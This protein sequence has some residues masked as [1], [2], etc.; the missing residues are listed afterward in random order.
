MAVAAL[1]FSIIAS[2][3]AV[4][5]AFY[6]YGATR[7]ASKSRNLDALITLHKDNLSE[8]NG[9]TRYKLL[10]S[11]DFDALTQPGV[12]S[13]AGPAAIDKLRD[14]LHGLLGLYEVIAT[15]ANEDLL[16][17]HLVRALFPSIPRVYDKAEIYI[18]N[19]R[20]SHPEFAVNLTAFRAT[21]STN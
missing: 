14:D 17:R 2:L 19:Y 16:D 18:I 20:K 3:G 8:E 10:H 4:A 21:Y 15:A 13:N 5:S 9:T 1:V 12:S 6:A 11:P 7:Q